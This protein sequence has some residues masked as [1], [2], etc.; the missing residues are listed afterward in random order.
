[1]KFRDGITL[2]FPGKSST[3]GVGILSNSV[4]TDDCRPLAEVNL[5]VWRNAVDFRINGHCHPGV[6]LA[7]HKAC[8]FH[9]GKTTPKLASR[10]GLEVPVS[11][12]R[13]VNA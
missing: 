1:M 9:A 2:C 8:R 3:F 11:F 6:A 12:E 4:R 7:A 13:K 5:F 10:P